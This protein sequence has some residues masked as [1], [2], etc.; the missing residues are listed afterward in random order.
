MSGAICWSLAHRV[1]VVDVWHRAIVPNPPTIVEMLAPDGRGLVLEP[2]LG[3]PGSFKVTPLLPSQLAMRIVDEATGNEPKTEPPP[4]KN[5]AAVALGVA[6]RTA[7]LTH[8]R[9]QEIAKKAATR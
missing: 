5:E 8:E 7:T 4:V 6:A 2:R 3:T 1:E 9:W